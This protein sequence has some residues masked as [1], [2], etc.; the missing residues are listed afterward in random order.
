[1]EEGLEFTHEKTSAN[2]IWARE[3][4][5][6]SPRLKT[7]PVK[8]TSQQPGLPPSVGM[9]GA[10]LPKQPPPEQKLQPCRAR[11]TH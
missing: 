8:S 11:R 9:L 10:Q 4:L 3:F 6:K 7:H 1:M 5:H 2:C